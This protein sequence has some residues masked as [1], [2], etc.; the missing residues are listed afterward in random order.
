MMKVV[1]KSQNDPLKKANDHRTQSPQKQVMI[2]CLKIIIKKM[3]AA[4][5]YQDLN[6]LKCHQIHLRS[7]V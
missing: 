2:R 7:T 5:V 6:F 3:M 4:R 1:V